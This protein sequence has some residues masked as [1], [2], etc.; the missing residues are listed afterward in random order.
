MFGA[1]FFGSGRRAR[2][3]DAELGKGVWRRAHDRF[4]R[5]LDRFHQMLEGAADVTEVYEA[6]VPLA[7]GVAG[8][9]PEVRRICAAAQELAPS[10]DADV[11][12]GAGAGLRDVH[13]ELSRAGN[14]LATA[15]GAVAMARMG[16]GDVAAVARH[17]DSVRRH[18][19]E[20]ARLLAP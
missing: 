17:C 6:L 8:L 2:R 4:V 3:D 13:R 16:D 14:S 18:V 1:A 10:V 9:L 7:D 19:E 15:A 11:P 12:A 5:G 20:A